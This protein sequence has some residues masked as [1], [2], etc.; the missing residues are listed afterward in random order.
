MDKHGKKMKGNQLSQK[1]GNENASSQLCL[2]IW[3]SNEERKIE[4]EKNLIPFLCNL[5]INLHINM[6]FYLLKHCIYVWVYYF[7][8]REKF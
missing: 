6:K 5:L 8:Y 2:Q 4:N 1:K 3:L 7:F